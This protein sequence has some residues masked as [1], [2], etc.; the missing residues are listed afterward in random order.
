MLTFTRPSTNSNT[1]APPLSSVPQPLQNLDQISI[2][3]LTRDNYPIRFTIIVPLL[4]RQNLYG[5]VNGDIS[6]PPSFVASPSSTS[7]LL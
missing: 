1:Q 5:F 6:P 2:L 3:K 7:T 4:E